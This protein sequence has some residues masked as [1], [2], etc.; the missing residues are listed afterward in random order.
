MTAQPL[1]SAL[2][3]PGTRPERI[4]KALASGADAVIVDLEDAVPPD[5]KTAARDNVRQFLAARPQARVCLRINAADSPEHD[6]DLALCEQVGI[7]TVL[8]PKADPAAGLDRIA[9][10]GKPLWLLVETASGL[11]GLHEL[12]AAAG[13]ERLALG[14]LDLMQDLDLVAG[15]EPAQKALDHARFELVV[16]SRAAGL[17]APIDGVFPAFGDD[18]GLQRAAVHARASGFGGL[19]CIHPRQV[20]VVNAAFAPTGAE[21]HWARRVVDAVQAGQGVVAVDG[22]M[23]D[24]PVIARARRLLERAAR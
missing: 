20:A 10:T 21:L 15:S 11:V 4:D 23:V 6:A 5:Q 1:R 7:A 9:A 2:F 19:L 13:V 3:V 12:V 8:L 17:A 16:Q 24:A 14:T 18:A 22:Q